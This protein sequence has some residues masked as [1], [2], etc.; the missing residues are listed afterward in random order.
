MK[1][2]IFQ[3]DLARGLAIILMTID[4]IVH[5]NPFIK[6]LS[7]PINIANS[8][9]FLVI[10]RLIGHICAPT[11]VLLCGISVYI[12]QINQKLSIAQISKLIIKRGFFLLL[13]NAQLLLLD[14]AL[15]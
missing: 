11:F 3:I 5:C 2:R 10:L 1:N 4:H 9:R 12:K 13:W 8:S 6:M 15:Q 14:G 7:D